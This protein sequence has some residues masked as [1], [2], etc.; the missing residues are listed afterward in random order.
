MPTRFAKELAQ[1]IRGAVAIGMERREALRLAIR[2][3]R[4]SMPPLRLA[5]IDDL[6]AN[7]GSSAIDVRKRI[8]KPRSTVDRQLQALHMLG[9]LD[10]SEEEAEYG[11]K[12]VAR[13]FYTIA[14][15]IE[16]RAINPNSLPDLSPPTPRPL[17][18]RESDSSR[19]TTPTDISGKGQ[20]SSGGSAS[21][22]SSATNG[23]ATCT[24]CAAKFLAVGQDICKV[25]AARKLRAM[26]DQTP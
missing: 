21:S 19:P 10:V 3:A 17:E 6:A 7:P 20:S 13:W 16:P 18:K 11:G 26:R 5:L 1:I 2:C 12:P 23:W 9:V 24:S 14:A 25:C 4:D 8:N 22:A 15:G